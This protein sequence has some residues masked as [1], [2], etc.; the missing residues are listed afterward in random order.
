LAV[1]PELCYGLFIRGEPGSTLELP[2]S[3]PFESSASGSEK[4]TL[5]A[6]IISTRANGKFVKD[7][8]MAFPSDWKSN[9]QPNDKIGHQPNG[10][11]ITLHS[12]AVSPVFQRSGLG[13]ALMNVYIDQFKKSGGVERISI[14]TYDR[15]VPYYN[16][17][18]FTHYGKSTSEYAGVAWHDLVS[19][20]PVS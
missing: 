15:L 11:T 7:E 2:S 18:G 1:C 12:L 5:L 17:L 19:H 20:R 14:L 3:I 9:P 4:E 6:H 16:K 10:K 13:K 8:D